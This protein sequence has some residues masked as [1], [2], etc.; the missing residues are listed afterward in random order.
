M[1]ARFAFVAAVGV[2]VVVGG[3]IGAVGAVV[4]VV[5]AA[6]VVVGVCFD[7]ASLSA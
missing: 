3:G 6:I 7:A 2:A 1:C 5:A 4:G